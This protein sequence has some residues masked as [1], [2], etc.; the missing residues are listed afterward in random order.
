MDKKQ[1]PYS[2]LTDCDSEDK[3]KQQVQKN[4]SKKEN[5]SSKT[6]RIV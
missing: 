3:K 1:K 2:Y 6:M 5:L 4:V